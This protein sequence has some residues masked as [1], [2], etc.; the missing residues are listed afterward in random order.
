MAEGTWFIGKLLLFLF[1]CAAVFFSLLALDQYWSDRITQRYLSGGLRRHRTAK[2]VT[3]ELTAA[4]LQALRKIGDRTAQGIVIAAIAVAVGIAWWF[5]LRDVASQPALRIL[6]MFLALGLIPALCALRAQPDNELRIAL[7]VLFLLAPATYTAVNNRVFDV[8]FELR[9]PFPLSFLEGQWF[10]FGYRPVSV[11]HVALEAAIAALYATVPAYAWARARRGWRI[12]AI[13]KPELRWLGQVLGAS[14]VVLAPL[15][16]IAITI[17]PADHNPFLM[18]Y[19][20]HL[21]FGP[22]QI[23]TLDVCLKAV[24]TLSPVY[25]AVVSIWW[26]RVC[27]APSRVSR[28]TTRRVLRTTASSRDPR[29]D[30]EQ[31]PTMTPPDP[32]GQAPRIHL[33]EGLARFRDQFPDLPPIPAQPIEYEGWF[34]DVGKRAQ[35]RSQTRTTAQHV[36]ML[37]GLNR[38]QKEWLELARTH[39]EFQRIRSR[40]VVEDKTIEAE[41]KEQELKIKRAELEIAKLDQEIAQVN[42]GQGREQESRPAE[43]LKERFTRGLDSI[44]GGVAAVNE[45]K[46]RMIEQDPQNKE[47][48]E[49]LAEDRCAA[50]KEGRWK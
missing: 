8:L 4:A 31:E 18:L 5:F 13:G 46:Q 14:A 44:R 41:L 17:S 45:W 6:F 24:F 11:I 29:E 27:T 32:I 3:S 1:V 12:G 28:L 49:D 9:V 40:G 38:L 42:A 35:I 43:S 48:I 37:E 50:I 22:R 47:L 16:I 20:R 25:A 21:D 26:A 2:P 39:L 15:V 23:L 33:R 36:A 10:L 30:E 7:A 34:A 19:I